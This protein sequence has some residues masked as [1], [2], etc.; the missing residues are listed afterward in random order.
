[1]VW[2]TTERTTSSLPL[3]TLPEQNGTLLIYESLTSSEPTL[4][5]TNGRDRG[6]TEGLRPV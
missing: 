3:P 2:A 5:S 4:K 6:E 1:M